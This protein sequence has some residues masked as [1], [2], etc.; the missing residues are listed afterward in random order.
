MAVRIGER[1]TP[2]DVVRVARGGEEVATTPEAEARVAASRALVERMVEEGR[3]VYGVTTGVGEL[4]HVRISP[5]QTAELNRNIVRSHAA[6]VGAPLPADVV[7]AMMVLRAHGLSL[8]YSGVRPVVVR[9]LIGMLNRGVVPV[10]PEQ[11]SVGASG[12]LAPLA[13]LALAMTGEGEAFLDGARVPAA[14]ALSRSGL[15]PL[16][17]GAK[18]GLALING[19]QLMTALGCLALADVERLAKTA[20][21]A[22]AMSLEA[23]LG[24]PEAF[25][26]LLQ[27]ARPHP[28]QLASARN[29]RRLLEGSEILAGRP[30][31]LRVQDAYSLRCMPQ[32]HGAAR[33]ALRFAREVLEREANSATDNPLVF[34]E[35][36]RVI[37][38][39]NFH[40]QPVAM[41]LDLL[42][43]A[44]SYLGAISERRI[45]RLVNP[46]LSNGLPPFLVEQSG[47][48]TGYMLAQYTA[49][50]LASENKALAYPASVD[51]IPTSAG[52]EDHVSMGPI[53]GRKALLVAA[54][55]ERVLGIELVCA[56]QAL[57]FR[58][59][60]RPAPGP[61]AALSSVRASVT[62]LLEDRPIAPDLAA[63]AD[64]V[65]SGA[66][67]HA[68][69]AAIGALE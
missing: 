19:T 64:L 21:V 3:V 61:S 39:G 31:P 30:V 16:V 6:G 25:D 37:S 63:G 56:A 4:A 28:G 51:T 49:A 34:A 32:V 69:E 7:R 48:R 24:T 40:G 10:V 17:L 23:L 47:L 50:A 44:V 57:E 53:A 2:D 55:A 45:E 67:V 35:A 42:A 5:E 9:L 11:G 59:P 43:I 38:G 54:N 27:H 29:L 13:H 8:G 26:P 62:R 14:D 46:H 1:V 22:G 36:G 15:E 58:L 33:D 20:D 52:H 65:R 66:A 12:D 60:A 41:V 68:A 18:E